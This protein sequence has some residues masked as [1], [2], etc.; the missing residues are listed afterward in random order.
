MIQAKGLVRTWGV[1]TNVASPGCVCNKSSV[2]VF[3]SIMKMPSVV[4]CKH[5]YNVAIRLSKKS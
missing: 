2:R 3:L 5:P 4:K 1:Q